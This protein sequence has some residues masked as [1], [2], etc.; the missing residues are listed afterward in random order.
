MVHQFSNPHFKGALA[1]PYDVIL[2]LKTDFNL[3][4]KPL[5]TFPVVMYF[6]KNSIYTK[7]FSDEIQRMV[8]SGLI[9]YWIDEVAFA[10]KKKIT[11]SSDPKVMTVSQLSA[12]FI[13][14]V[15]GYAISFTVFLIEVFHQHF[16]LFRHKSFVRPFSPAPVSNFYH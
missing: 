1:E 4:S 12:P 7:I 14:C 13:F 2:R 9:K 3:L 15:C 5:S 16:M 11:P 6:Q 8:S 10:D